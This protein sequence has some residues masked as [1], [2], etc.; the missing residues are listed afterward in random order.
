[1]MDKES[2]KYSKLDQLSKAD[3]EMLSQDNSRNSKNI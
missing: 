2:E 3:H 1:M